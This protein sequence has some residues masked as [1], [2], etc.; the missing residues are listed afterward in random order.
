M[1]SSE[2]TNIYYN[3]YS[4]VL[5]LCILFESRKRVISPT[6]R[7]N[8]ILL[9]FS[10]LFIF[11]LTYCVDTDFFSY[12]KMV[13]DYDF[14]PGAH[15]HGEKI[16]GYLI[17]FLNK[18]YFLFRAIVWGV[19]LFLY[20]K[21]SKLLKIDTKVSISILSILFILTFSYAR[22]S[23]GMAVFFYGVA[24]FL[25]SNNLIS[26]WFSFIIIYSSCFFHSSM[27]ALIGLFLVAVFMPLNKK[28]VIVYCS[29]TI[30]LAL[31]INQFMD[32]IL[33]DS[34]IGADA[35]LNEKLTGYV[36]HEV[37][38]PN[39]MGIFRNVLEYGAFYIPF[40]IIT[41]KLYR[42]ALIKRLPSNI[43]F[44]F[45]IL[46]LL[47]MLTTS[48][49]FLNIS[50]SVFFYRYLFMSMLPMALLI[51]FFISNNLFT[52]KERT[53]ILGYGAIANIY[54]LLYSVY[55]MI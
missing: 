45:K 4:L 19:A 46:L 37:V 3:I 55:V 51:S 34:V 52:H 54:A 17:Y 13:R 27:I 43:I 14:T 44:I 20:Y 2:E 39:F 36:E 28:M 48:L 40:I 23:L 31:S 22:A 49:F 47:M 30:V 10:L 1:F 35:S 33:M 29:L 32:Y 25:K 38:G 24:K 12:M 7:Q 26:K 15:N 5:Y 50:S 16:Y 11:V 18:N 41:L 53:W 8:S 6:K 9:L 21:T 42:R